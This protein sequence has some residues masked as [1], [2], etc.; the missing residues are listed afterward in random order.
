VDKATLAVIGEG[1]EPEAVIPLSKIGQ[2]AAQMG[3]NQQ[4]STYN[5]HLDGILA[6]SK[7][8][9]RDIILEGLQAVDERRRAQGKPAILKGGA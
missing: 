4:G 8:E 1:S 3:V 5:I 2:V 6:R 7:S 9:M